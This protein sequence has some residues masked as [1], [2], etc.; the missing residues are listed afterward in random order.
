MHARSQDFFVGGGGGGGPGPQAREQ[1]GQ[2]F[3]FLFFFLVINLFYSVQR[4]PM[5]LLQ[6]KLNF[7]KDPEGVQHFPGESNFF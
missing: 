5:V 2:R 6:S 4:G 7:S 3:F 1:P